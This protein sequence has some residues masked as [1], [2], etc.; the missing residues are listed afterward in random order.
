MFR[1]KLWR[2]TDF[3]LQSLVCSSLKRQ[4]THLHRHV[5]VHGR[6]WSSTSSSEPYYITTPIFYANACKLRMVRCNSQEDAE[7]WCC[8]APHIGHLYNL[9]YADVLKRWHLLDGRKAL[10][11][12]GTDEHG[13]K[14]VPQSCIFVEE[15]KMVSRSSVQRK[16]LG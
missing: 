15:A 9:V 2:W 10:L 8:E 16:Q 4:Q 1:C 3:E 6:R 11:C 14:V 7:Y 5:A 13:I 12:T